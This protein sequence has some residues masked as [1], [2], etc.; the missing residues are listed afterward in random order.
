MN[1]LTHYA[2][3]LALSFSCTEICLAATSHRSL[4][5]KTSKKVTG[6]ISGRITIK[7]KG[8]GGI[9]VGAR[10]GD[11]M[12]G[13]VPLLKAIT[14][15]D[16]NYRVANLPGGSYQITPIAPA[17]VISD[18]NSFGRQGKVVMLTAGENVEGIDFQIVRGGV[19]S[20]K[21]NHADGRP[22]IEERIHVVPVEPTDRQAISF[23]MQSAS[24]FQTDD[25][26]FYRIFGL[27]PGKYKISI[28]QG[29]NSFG[30]NIGGPSRSTYELTFY[31]D[32]AN[33]NEAKVVDLGEGAEATNI[34]I[35]VG[36]RIS[37]FAAAGV[38]IDR[39]T[40]K[41]IP[42]L[43]FG[44]QRMIGDR[45]SFVSVSV[46][47][48]RLGAF[49]FENL[50]P[51]KYSVVN[52]PQPNT[53]LRAESVTF[54]VVDQDVSGLIVRAS[55]GAS[56]SGT[57]VVEGAPDKTAQSRIGRFSLHAY[58]RNEIGGSGF[59]E[60]SLINPDGSFL[61]KGLQAGVIQF[62][63][64]AQ[65][66]GSLTGF[67]ISRVELDGVVLPRGVEIEPGQNI[68]GV[69]IFVNYGSGSVRGII[70]VEK[71]SLP[72]NT[73]YMVRLTKSDDP[74]ITVGRTDVD[75]RGRFSVEG[76]PA[77]AYE[78]YVQV[79]I[80]ESRVRPPTS[81]QSINVTEGSVTEVEVVLDLEA[82]LPLA[83]SF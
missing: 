23:S 30:D 43:R 33:P 70:K 57:V 69:R 38:V 73:R 74:S 75:A 45:G 60:S 21:V 11:S 59:V 8:K 51:G 67:V 79:F 14:D 15:Q 20:G 34:D 19:I 63:L 4:Q 18:F 55:K 6:S 76:V 72:A 77:G 41:P 78:L 52:M 56:V 28:G 3:I 36:Q 9:V 25:R 17:Y 2:I 48:D 7:G 47:S 32:P 71:G 10:A 27:P 62:Q 40:N 31:S 49:Q 1:G 24:V 29:S 22:L 35:T 37:A 44:L 54:E 12:P 81:R 65:D 61:I 13:M 82:T 83:V 5:N 39:E 16:G 53:E 58:N 80:P 42:N 50:T 46:Q 68:S 66:R 26:G 64:S